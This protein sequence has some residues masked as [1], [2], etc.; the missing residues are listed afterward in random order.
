MD[1]TVIE[2]GNGPLYL[3]SAGLS[4]PHDG[5][6]IPVQIIKTALT[7]SLLFII[8]KLWVRAMYYLR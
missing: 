7:M 5:R 2:A 8:R 6:M 3:T 1:G 4:D